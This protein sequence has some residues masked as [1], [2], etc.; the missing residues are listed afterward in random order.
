MCEQKVCKHCSIG[1]IDVTL[2]YNVLVYFQ[3]LH[4]GK[5]WAES[6]LFSA[7]FTDITY[8]SIRNQDKCTRVPTIRT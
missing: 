2:P 1:S 5:H 6:I 8:K 7:V 3:P 4:Y